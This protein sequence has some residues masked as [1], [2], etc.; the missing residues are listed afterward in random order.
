MAILLTNGKCYIALKES[1]AV[2]KVKNM[3]EAHDFET[4]KR[5]KSQKKMAPG[6]TA[7]YYYMD[8]CNEN[9]WFRPTMRRRSFTI[10]ERLS[11]YRKSKGTCYL[12]GE[13]V[14]FNSFEIEHRIPLAKGGT[15]ELSNLFPSCHIC[16]TIKSDIFPEDF[17]KRITRIF[18]YQMQKQFG[19]NFRWKFIHRSLETLLCLESKRQQD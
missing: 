15:N 5:A 8:T 9:D 10:G 17:D 1:G 6:K 12:C 14:D 7:G 3:N 18:L 11:I 13:F 2:T 19:D 16:N 4:V